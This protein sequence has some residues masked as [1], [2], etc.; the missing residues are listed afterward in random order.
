L[1]HKRLSDTDHLPEL[2]ETVKSVSRTRDE[3]L[4]SLSHELRIPLTTI[5]GYTT[6]LLLEEVDWSPEKR[7][8][9]LRMIEKECDHME[10]MLTE[11]LDS[12]LI[13]INRLNLEFEPLL[14]PQIARKIAGEIQARSEYHNLI[15]DFPSDFPL[16]EAD[17]HWIQQVLRNILDNSIKY[18]P[19][20]G[21][22]VLRG[23]ARSLNVV[24]SVSDQGIGISPEDLMSIFERYYRAKSP[25][26]SNIPGTGLGLPI[27]RAIVEAH[28]GR[29]WAESKLGQG[30][31]MSFSL[32]TYDSSEKQEGIIIQS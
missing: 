13:E 2:L 30:T 29:I 6:A 17:T 27:A 14:L 16:V 20:G 22:I 10:V 15:V 19:E 31:T 8:E 21:L 9:F 5:K 26:V 32:P 1:V 12:S 4:A 28:G 11:I 24:I 18:S 7:Q 25:T 3:L 23:E